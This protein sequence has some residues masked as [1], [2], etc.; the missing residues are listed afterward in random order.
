M[1]CLSS[2]YSVIIPLHVSGV[3]AAHHQEEEFIYVA[4]DT[5]YTSKLTV[6]RPGLLTVNLE[7]QQE[8]SICHI[9]STSWWWTADKRETCRGVLTE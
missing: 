6:S 2:V 1:Y 8:P 3:S 7:V 4:N 5:C 9:Y